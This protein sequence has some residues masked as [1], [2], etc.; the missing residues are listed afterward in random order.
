MTKK[1]RLI[2][3]VTTLFL[4]GILAVGGCFLSTHQVTWSTSKPEAQYVNVDCVEEGIG[5]ES[6]SSGYITVRYCSEKPLKLLL[7]KDTKDIA[8]VLSNK[9]E[10]QVI[11]LGEGEGTYTFTVGEHLRAYSYVV[12]E[13]VELE[14]EFTSEEMPFLIPS[15]ACPYSSESESVRCAE[16]IAVLSTD[17]KDFV[18]NVMRWIDRSISYDENM[19]ATPPVNYYSD[20]DKT[21]LEG[22]GVC[23]DTATLAAAMLR[24]QG[25]PTKIV[26]GYI[27]GVDKLH[28]WNMIYLN[29]AWEIYGLSPYASFEVV[30][31]LKTQ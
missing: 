29:N 1:I 12:L 26:T 3:V 27:K 4:L 9:N 5:L 23:I 18:E 16:K 11:P 8:Y 24:S 10:P 14:V 6:S 17:K 31:V 2:A 25:V 19:A 30:Q 13:T 20:P 21:F 22:K 7:E 28:A 15:I